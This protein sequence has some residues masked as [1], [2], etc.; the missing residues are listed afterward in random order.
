MKSQRLQSGIKWINKLSLYLYSM[1][2]WQDFIFNVIFPYSVI[3]EMCQSLFWKYEI[4]SK[5]V[6][7][8]FDHW[9]QCAIN[10]CKTILL[11]PNVYRWNRLN[12]VNILFSIMTSL[13]LIDSCRIWRQ[14]N[15]FE[16]EY[17]FNWDFLLYPSWFTLFHRDFSFSIGI[18][19]FPLGFSLFHWDF[20]VS[21][22][23]SSFPLGFLLFNCDFSFILFPFLSIGISLSHTSRAV[24]YELH[25]PW[26]AMHLT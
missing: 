1:T 2:P 12:R 11:I 15:A 14:N 23:I 16:D 24:A 9:W 5:S 19:S 25:V 20:F 17:L 6:F 18:S 7:F 22:G 4:T 26:V 3:N 10:Y 21:S 8:T 13:F